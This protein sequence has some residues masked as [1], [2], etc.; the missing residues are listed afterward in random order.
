MHSNL[1][2]IRWPFFYCHPVGCKTSLNKPKNLHVNRLHLK[3]SPKTKYEIQTC[4][5]HVLNPKLDG[6]ELVI[7]LTQTWWANRGSCLIW[8]NKLLS[9]NLKDYRCEIPSSS[10][11]SRFLK[12]WW[13]LQSRVPYG[14]IRFL[15]DSLRFSIVAYGCF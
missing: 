14:S 4:L 12:S 15:K 6:K 9:E 2:C 3:V 1:L 13:L 10:C 5:A 7:L 11:F 8:N